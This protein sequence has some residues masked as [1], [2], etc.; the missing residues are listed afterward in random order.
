MEAPK[1]VATL[2]KP[3][4][5]AVKAPKLTREQCI[6]SLHRIGCPTDNSTLQLIDALLQAPD[7]E[8]LR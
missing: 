2:S 4:I 5:A 7:V 6:E 3:A 8:V 1:I